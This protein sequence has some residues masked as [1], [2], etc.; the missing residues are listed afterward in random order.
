M[1]ELYPD[2]PYTKFPGE[3]DNMSQMM[4]ITASDLPTINLF[5]Y[6]LRNGD[7][8]AAQLLFRTVP[9]IDKKLIDSTRLNQLRDAMI[10]LERF[11]KTDIKPYTDE[12]SAEWLMK[13]MQFSYKGMWN[14]STTYEAYNLVSYQSGEDILMFIATKDVTG[15]TGINITN[16]EYWTQFTIRGERGESGAGGSFRYNWNAAESYS[17]NDTVVYENRI[18]GAKQAN[19]NSE[20]KLDG[21]N[22]NWQ[23][24]FKLPSAQIPV[25]SATETPTGLDEGNMYFELDGTYSGI[26]Y[27]NSLRDMI[28]NRRNIT[29]V[30]F[31]SGITSIGDYAFDKC[32]SLALTS[33]PNSITSIGNYAFT[34]CTS[35]ALTSL[36]NS[37][38]SIGNNAFDNCKSLAL[39][40]LPNSITSISNNAFFNC[41]SLALTNLPNSITSIGDS[42]FSNCTSLALTSLPNSITSISS[43]AFSGCTSLALTSLPNSITSISNNAFSGCTNLALTSLPSELTSIDSY[44]FSNCTSLALTSLPSELTSI[45]RSAFNNCTSLTSLRI[46]SNIQTIDSDAFASCK[47][48]TTIYINLPRTTV[49]AMSGYRSKWGAKNATIICNDD[50]GWVEA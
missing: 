31:P 17:I 25:F 3:L 23:E 40:S 19:T 7:F 48:L 49:E 50:A 35:L 11:Y 27:E 12:K 14:G 30:D 13:V 32:K 41:T 10:A 39:T 29:S 4:N 43:G 42:A 2:L 18:W 20:P 37:I 9:D 5:H 45:D 28:S 46:G 33:L 24:L 8:E 6:Y 16:T 15:G 22:S 34:F 1:S 44:A 47:N 26:S 36:P 38:T 21:S